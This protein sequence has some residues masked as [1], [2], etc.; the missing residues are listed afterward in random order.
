[1][2]TTLSRLG[3]E[4]RNMLVPQSRTQT[5]KKKEIFSETI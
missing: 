2:D 3:E 1:M 4:E 5:D